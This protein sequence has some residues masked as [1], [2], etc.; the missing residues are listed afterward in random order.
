MKKSLEMLRNELQPE[1][2]L[3][4]EQAYEIKGG[5]GWKDVVS[6][7]K[8]AFDYAKQGYEL[9]QKNKDYIQKVWSWVKG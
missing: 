7:T 1:S 4:F 9:Y 6:G 8:K 5:W 3:T 2:I